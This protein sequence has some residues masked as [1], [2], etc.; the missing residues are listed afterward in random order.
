MKRS[1]EFKRRITKELS[2]N[3]IDSKSVNKIINRSVD[4]ETIILD[5][6]DCVLYV[7]LCDGVK[8]ENC[9]YG[10]IDYNTL[11]SLRYDFDDK[12]NPQYNDLFST[13]DQWYKEFENENHHITV[14]IKQHH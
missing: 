5:D 14:Q 3:F 12:E 10:L 2:T 9:E 11:D 8:L 6:N 4:E 1:I 13:L 7:I